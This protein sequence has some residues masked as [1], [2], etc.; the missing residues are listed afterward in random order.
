MTV[1]TTVT[2]NPT[3]FFALLIA[4][5]LSSCSKQSPPEAGAANN[6]ENKAIA[7]EVTTVAKPLNLPTPQKEFL[8]VEVISGGNAGETVVLP[9]HVAFRPQAQSVV[10]ATV[11]GRVVAQ[12]VRAGEVVRAGAP[13][14]VIESADA[15][16][17]RALVDQAATKVT[18]AEQSHRRQVEM[19]KKGVGIEAELQEAEARLKDA[20]AE[21]QRAQ[22]AVDLIGGG[23][24][25]RVTVR[26]PSSGV[27]TAIKVAVG[28]TVSPGGDALIELGNPSLLQIVALA[29]ES[30]LQ[31][32]TIGQTSEVFI[33]AL[34]TTTSARVESITPSIDPELRRTQIYLALPKRVEGLQAG[35]LSDVKI[36]LGHAAKLTIPTSAVLIR[37]GARRVVYVEKADGSYE[38]RDVKIGSNRDGKVSI[39]SGLTAGER[40]VTRGA[41]LLDTQAELLL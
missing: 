26:A 27:V 19:L 11:A 34:N 12:M 14:L 38:A 9:A 16:G 10:G 18:I 41:L 22:H 23:Q 28:A 5:G 30:D 4:A 25:S 20:R 40:I 3:I 1:K 39:L 36:R 32:I 37:Q 21:H 31:G 6:A 17:T 7:R 24:G 13:L 35:M 15:A 8:T 33:P 29:A 2:L